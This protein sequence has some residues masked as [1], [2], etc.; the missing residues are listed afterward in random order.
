MIRTFVTH[1]VALVIVL[2]S[3]LITP[4]HAYAHILLKPC[5]TE[6]SVMCYWDGQT[7]GNGHG[8][9]FWTDRRGTVHF[10]TN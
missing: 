7:R 1:V 6:D 4:N 8:R 3:T 2:I 9:S 10:L 5:V